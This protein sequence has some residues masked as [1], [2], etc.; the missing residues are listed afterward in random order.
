MSCN[1]STAVKKNRV[2]TFGMKKL[3]SSQ[4]FNKAARA[5][6]IFVD[7]CA[8]I[9]SI[10]EKDAS[11]LTTRTLQFQMHFCIILFAWNNFVFE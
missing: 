2:R 9:A 4:K 6:N 3:A 5:S 10:I 8:R 1:S 11:F 7:I